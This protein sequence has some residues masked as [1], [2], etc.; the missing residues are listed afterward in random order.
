MINSSYWLN[1]APTPFPAV[2][3]VSYLRIAKS[4]WDS[5]KK[6]DVDVVYSIPQLLNL[7]LLTFGEVAVKRKQLIGL[8]R[9]HKPQCMTL[10]V[11]HRIAVMGRSNMNV[12]TFLQ[13]QCIIC[14]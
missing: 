8:A 12:I 9:Y 11:N 10:W 14:S 1:I 13:R 7:V 2:L 4:L 5:G 6:K 3:Q